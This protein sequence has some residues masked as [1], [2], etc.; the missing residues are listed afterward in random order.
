M[1]TSRGFRS[2][3]DQLR[4]WPDERLSRLLT[5]RP[6]LAT[7]APHDFGQL[8]SRASLRT[9]LIRALDILTRLEL[10]VLD[11]LVVAGQTTSTELRS[12]VYA[13]RTDVD[14]ALER[15]QDLA[16]AWESPGGDP[17]ADRAR[18]GARG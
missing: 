12:I 15:L 16:L 1:A 8:A 17:T 9:S 5:E 2:L 6:D 11:A 4:S 7:P 13:G 10:F 14:A 3:A 18:R